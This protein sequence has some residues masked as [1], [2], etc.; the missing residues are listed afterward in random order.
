MNTFQCVLATGESLPSGEKPSFAIFL[1]PKDGIKWTTGDYSGGKNGLGG[2]PAQAGINA[3]DGNRCTS[4]CEA[5][6][7]EIVD[8]DKGSNVKQDGVY[9]YRVDGTTVTSP[10]PSAI[11]GQLY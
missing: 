5:L 4:V 7:D 9:I 10:D 3:G 11:K 2:T 8:I 6:T 1:Y